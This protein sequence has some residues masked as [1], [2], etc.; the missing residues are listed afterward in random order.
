[1][2]TSWSKDQRIWSVPF[3]GETWKEGVIKNT[4]GGDKSKMR[5][6]LKLALVLIVGLF[7]GLAVAQIIQ[8]YI[9]PT[10]GEIA[11]IS[12]SIKWLNGT[13][14]ETTGINWGPTENSTWYVM[15]PINITNLSNIPVN[16]T[17]SWIEKTGIITMQLDW[18]FS[19]N[20]LQPNN[21]EIVELYQNVTAT[22]PY[23]YDTIIRGIEA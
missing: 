7:I 20:T 23:T 19:G 10:T 16:L 17:L 21:Y 14:V 12:L 5:N 22:G 6:T 9:F 4:L 3:V 1:M 8:Q 11:T 18:N 2:D 13:D 15:D